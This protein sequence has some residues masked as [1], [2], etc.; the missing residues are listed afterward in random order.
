MRRKHK[1]THQQRGAATQARRTVETRHE[2]L[3]VCL[4]HLDS[5]TGTLLTASCSALSHLRPLQN[6]CIPEAPQGYYAY[7]PTPLG[8]MRH[9]VNTVTATRALTTTTCSLFPCHAFHVFNNRAVGSF[10]HKFRHNHEWYRLFRNAD[11]I[12][13]RLLLGSRR[14]T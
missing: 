9:T 13:G 1:T 12:A 7:E 8:R 3:D 4:Q 11:N 14:P 10:R 6:E 5:P 2:V